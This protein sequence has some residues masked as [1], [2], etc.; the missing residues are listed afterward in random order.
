MTARLTSSP[1]YRLL[2][3][4]GGSIAT[5]PRHST[6]RV[7]NNDVVAS[8]ALEGMMMHS[9]A[10]EQ[11]QSEHDCDTELGEL[12]AK[13]PRALDARG[14]DHAARVEEDDPKQDVRLLEHAT[15]ARRLHV[16]KPTKA[17]P[18]AEHT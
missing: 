12:G 10:N 2:G 3:G 7:Y 11:R 18:R 14:V 9:Q 15:R 1:G 4:R 8:K 13:W 5:G 6:Q 17:I 16:A